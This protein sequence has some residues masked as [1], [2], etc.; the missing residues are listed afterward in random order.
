M[1]KLFGTVAAL[2]V[3]A[4]LSTQTAQAQD[5]K[6]VIAKTQDVYKHMKTLQASFETDLEQGA[7]KAKITT[8]VSIL[9][10]QK[11]SFNVHQ[12]ASAAAGGAAR[13]GDQR[14]VD[15]G[16]NYYAY[17]SQLNQYIKRPH[18]PQ[19]I[20]QQVST[21]Y[22]LPFL[23]TSEMTPK[24]LPPAKV[25]GKS[26]YI[27]EVTSAKPQ[28]KGKILITIDQATYHVRQTKLFLVNPK[29]NG[30]VTTTVKS[31]TFNAPISPAVFVFT[32]PKGA[33]EFVPPPPGAGGAPGGMGAPPAPRP[34]GMGAAP[35]PPRPGGK[36]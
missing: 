24:L 29:G 8:Q 36:P 35:P 12:Q 10:G 33:K 30:T 17:I 7:Q 32:P 15:D 13:T 26:A 27:I 23:S 16:V 4:S 1:Q 31:E 14:V 19:A 11:A 20:L 6:A 25:D 22:G 5:V 34:G 21:L 28:G 2:G 3:L 18:N 9:A